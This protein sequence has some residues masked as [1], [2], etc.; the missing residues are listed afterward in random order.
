MSYTIRTRGFNGEITKTPTSVKITKVN[1]LK[2]YDE[3]CIPELERHILEN[4]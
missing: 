3:G 2:N 1:C 4:P